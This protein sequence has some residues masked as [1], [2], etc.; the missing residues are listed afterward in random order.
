M[1]GHVAVVTGTGPG[2][3]R[4]CA[5]AFCREGADVVIAARDE[6]RLAALAADL[7]ASFP[8]ATVDT[9][10]F[11]LTDASS[12]RALIADVE[13]A[14]GGVDHL[15]NVAAAG[16]GGGAL[17]TADL[18][19]WRQAFEANVIGT[20]ELS[21]SAARSMADRRAGTIVQISTLGARSLPK[22]QAAYTS[23]K[24]AMESASMTLAKEVGPSGVRVNIVVPGYITGEGLDRL[25]A[26]S[27]ETTGEDPAVV[28]ERMASTASLKRHVDPADIAEAALFLSS[29]R[30]R[31][32]TGVA[33]PVTAGQ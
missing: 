14:I 32:I 31:C 17:D 16:G 22:R 23:T 10:C 2:V 33:L 5:E 21:R 24:Q 15:V 6:A 1:H 18:D 3:G 26:H 12:C 9:R 4:A 8:G 11:D 13:E 28:S 19:G 30:A 29:E 25:V 20:L 7:R 27:A